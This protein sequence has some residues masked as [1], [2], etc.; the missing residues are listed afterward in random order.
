MPNSPDPHLKVRLDKWLWAARF[1]KTRAQAKKAIV[2][3]KILVDGKRIKPAREITPGVT[4]NIRKDHQI[5][6]ILVD[7]LS[8]QRGSATIARQLYTET[9]TS[10]EQRELARLQQ[11]S[12]HHTFSSRPTSRERR[13]AMSFREN[14]RRNSL[15][16]NNKQ[17]SDAQD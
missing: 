10:I 11:K 4:L 5:W 17:D 14:M 1:F 15:Q 2:G 7:N 9:P 12:W 3:G 8:S 13:Q 16:P 6:E